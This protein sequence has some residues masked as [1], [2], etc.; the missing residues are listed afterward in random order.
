[1]ATLIKILII[2]LCMNICLTL[3][4]LSLSNY[5]PLA[6]FIDI[7]GSTVTPTDKFSL[8]DGNSVLPTTINQGQG[9]SPT[10]STGFIDSLVLIWSFIQLVFVS[11]FLPVYW[12]FVLGLPIWVTLL[13]VVQTIVGVVALVLVIKGVSD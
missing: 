3:M 4:G 7:D 9:V 1:M 6:G 5:S 13:L 8:D 12:G 10:T 2:V 11:I